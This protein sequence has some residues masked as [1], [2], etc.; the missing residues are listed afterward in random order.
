MPYLLPQPVREEFAPFVFFKDVF[1]P[2][3]CTDIVRNN[4]RDMK[5]ALT[6]KGDDPTRVSEV[7]WI[8]WNTDTDWIFK[9]LSATV[10]GCNSKW[11][12]FHLSAFGEPLQL[13][14]YKGE[15]KG[16]YDWHQDWGGN[17][18]SIR[19][20]SLVTLLSDVN[21]FTGGEFEVFNH[22]PVKELT[23]GTVLLFPSFQVHRV[24]QILSGT[25]W[26]LVSWVSG[27]QFV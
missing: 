10:F 16:H 4:S 19:K 27:P 14:K 25:R 8:E 18:F 23:Q 22:G 21:D 1:T 5:K 26:S 11:Y 15:D 12:N 3:E 2:Q 6:A 20:L 17:A 24:N 9:K 13:T 7:G